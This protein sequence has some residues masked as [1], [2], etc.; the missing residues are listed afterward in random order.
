MI[1]QT[2]GQFVITQKLGEGSMGEV[3]KARDTQVNREVAIKL[4]RRD[5]A[6]LSNVVD[7]FRQEAQ[8]LAQ[9]NHP[10]IAGLY[11]FFQ[12]ESGHVMAIEYVPGRTL[13]RILADHG[14]LDE[15]TATGIA[16]QVL[17]ALDHAH[18]L[19][20]IHRDIKPANIMVSDAGAVK[21]TDFSIAKIV[22]G[23][24]LTKRG[25]IVGTMEY[26][27]PERLQGLPSD[28]RADLYSTGAVLYETLTGHVPFEREREV[29][30][31]QAHIRDL[32]P[33]MSSH[34]RAVS[35]AVEAV[36]MRA[37]AKDPAERFANAAAF[38]QALSEA[39][40]N[41]GATPQTAWTADAGAPS[42]WSQFSGYTIPLPGV[43]ARFSKAP[44]VAA[45]TLA[46]ILFVAAIVMLLIPAAPAPSRPPVAPAPET[47]TDPAP[48]PTPP[49]DNRFDPSQG[50]P[51]D[52][53]GA[54]EAQPPAMPP[55]A[56]D[57][58]QQERRRK[59]LEALG[60]DD[61]NP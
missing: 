45:V 43:P 26:M 39:V 6:T 53:S 4:L 13:E 11:T 34:G 15:G 61:G 2:V 23:A 41:P 32:P 56:G 24:K 3:Y 44:V 19:G 9:L 14:R 42:M 58:E 36:T 52:T 18:S 33:P 55:A 29:D 38:Q 40:S 51:V 12:H 20:V 10:N 49:P 27:A 31:I 17:A 47:A 25:S 46:C 48:E 57:A 60:I 59:A 7:R 37:L 35:P 22:G 30:L 16:F 54:N 50:I 8:S 1:G 28:S 21:V 5:L